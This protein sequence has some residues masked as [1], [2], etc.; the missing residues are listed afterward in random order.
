M[1]AWVLDTSSSGMS[2]AH[3][4]SCM[5]SMRPR[6]SGRN[7]VDDYR[8]INRELTLQMPAS[9]GSR[10]SL[11]S[12][13]WMF[14]RTR[15]SRAMQDVLLVDGRRGFEIS[16]VSGAVSRAHQH[17]SDT[18]RAITQEVDEFDDDTAPRILKRHLRSTGRLSV[19]RIEEGCMRCAAQTWRRPWRGRTW[20]ARCGGV[21]AHETGRSGCHRSPRRPRGRPPAIPSSSVTTSSSTAPGRRRAAEDVG[22]QGPAARQAFAAPGDG[23]GRSALSGGGGAG[24]RHQ[25]ARPAADAR[26]S[27]TCWAVLPPL[28]SHISGK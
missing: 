8:A 15:A 7:P 24:V 11:R 22:G 18:L 25:T 12:T 9:A 1:M 13:R 27:S 3:V 26:Q 28:A 20:T 17:V 14:V 21:A 5:S 2:S 19:E 4:C 6:P 16:A 23:A 10:R